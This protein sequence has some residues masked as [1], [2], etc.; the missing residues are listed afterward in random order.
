MT[1]AVAA[2]GAAANFSVGNPYLAVDFRLY[3]GVAKLLGESG[4]PY[5]PHQIFPIIQSVRHLPPSFV[6]HGDSFLL[7]PVV[8]VLL[9]PLALVPFWTSFLVSAALGAA[10][11]A[12][13]ASVLAAELGLQ[14]WRWTVGGST[15]LW[16]PSVL[17]LS[18][19]QFEGLVLAGEAI[20][21]WLAT[22]ERWY[23]VGLCLTFVWLKPN[24]LWPTVLGVT[25]AGHSGR[26]AMRV[27]AGF[28]TGSGVL[29]A[30]VLARSSGLFPEWLRYLGVFVHREPAYEHHLIGITGLLRDSSILP[31]GA[32]GLG[33]PLGLGIASLGLAAVV[34]WSVWFRAKGS[35][36]GPSPVQTWQATLVPL[37]IWLTF[38]P[39]GHVNDLLCLLP[40]LL[41]T[42]RESVATGRFAIAE[43]AFW[44]SCEASPRALPLPVLAGA[45]TALL[46]IRALRQAHLGC[47]ERYKVASG[48]RLPLPAT[49]TGD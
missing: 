38:A 8:A 3:D 40:L 41:L 25:L 35:V 27:L 33:A 5:S 13:S 4:N 9:I 31:V 34:V 18:V 15:L 49:A 23:S 22:R 11:I 47:S 32:L 20:L 30:L 6:R 39:Y 36:A 28:C 17:S 12:I 43:A 19:G 42:L 24:I 14:R 29:T 44:V 37:G 46:T 7:L 1:A 26:S 48:K 16:W 10:L 21:L 2:V 45:G